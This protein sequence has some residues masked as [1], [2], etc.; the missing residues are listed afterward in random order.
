MNLEIQ[1]DREQ[2]LTVPC[3][4]PPLGCAAVEGSV[5]T[6]PDG[7]GGRTELE[8]FAAHDARLKAAGVLHAPLDSRELRRGGE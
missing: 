5:C 3:P 6:R 2:A 4:P 1:A 7:L 8:R